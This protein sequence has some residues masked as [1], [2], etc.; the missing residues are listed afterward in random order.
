MILTIVV[1]LLVLGI[2]L[3][4]YIQGFFS[5]TLSAILVIFAA[6]IALSYQETVINMLKPTKFA[7]SA[8][9]GVLCVL[10]IVSYLV[11]RII[12]DKLVPGNVRF[13]AT[14]DK[15][16]AGAMGLIAGVFTMGIFS[17][18]A[19]SMSFDPGSMYA[20]YEQVGEKE[21][22]GS[23]K[24]DSSQVE[25]K[26]Y[27]QMKSPKFEAK[28]IKGMVLPVDDWV[29]NTVK[30]LSAGSLSTDQKWGDIHPDYLQELFG[31]RI[32]M[33]PGVKH[34][35]V[36]YPNGTQQVSVEG[37]YLLPTA[38]PSQDAELPAVR[39]VNP[40]ELDE[41]KPEK[42][43]PVLVVRVKMSPDTADSSDSVI[44]FSLGSVRMLVPAAPPERQ[45]AENM[46]PIGTVE[47][48]K[49]YLSRVDDYLF[50]DGKADCVIDFAFPLDDASQIIDAQ[51]DPKTKRQ[52]LTVK[53]GVM[54]EVKRF[55]RVDLSGKPVEAVVMPPAP[56]AEA[57]VIRKLLVKPPPK[58]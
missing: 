47:T 15:V 11:M 49:L 36:N 48:G 40:Q 28:D 34:V 10:F 8:T 19:E 43:K 18:A 42:G 12:F 54:I 57:G 14:V 39:K 9:A 58:K 38:P 3:I 31:Q 29:V 51:G 5:A 27:D 33:Q 41:L 32:G 53:N 26:V 1:I 56:K 16:G 37:V 23:Y 21:A 45:Q 13:S 7:D 2:A 30:G 6:T 4:H 25:R 52:V 46:Y 44:S 20:R 50:A 17:V 22:G 35:A 24:P 55:G